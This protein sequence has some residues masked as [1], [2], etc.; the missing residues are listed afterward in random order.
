MSLFIGCTGLSELL[1]FANALSPLCCV[2]QL[3]SLKPIVKTM[4][5]LR[6]MQAARNLH[7]T[8]FRGRAI[9]VRIAISIYQEGLDSFALRV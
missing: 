9:G 3:I 1:L 4:V 6:D 2:P 5:K 7:G 8:N